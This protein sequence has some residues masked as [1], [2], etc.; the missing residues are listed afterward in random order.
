MLSG[1][2]LLNNYRSVHMLLNFY[3]EFHEEQAVYL[4]QL[5]L[6]FNKLSQHSVLKIAI[7]LY[8]LT[9]LQFEHSWAG[10]LISDPHS[11]ACWGASPGARGSTSKM[12]HSRGWQVGA[13]YRFLSTL[14]CPQ[15]EGGAALSHSGWVPQE[16]GR[17]T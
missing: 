3:D 9:N 14:T 8:L 15:E 17:S 4:F 16:Q 2:V 11:S 6:L 5:S 10:L 13:G 7:V 1:C 12:A